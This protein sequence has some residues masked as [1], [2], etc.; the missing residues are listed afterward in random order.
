MCYAAQ[1]WYSV[2]YVWYCF[3]LAR[4]SEVEFSAATAESASVVCRQGR[5]RWRMATTGNGTVAAV[6]QVSVLVRQYVV[7]SG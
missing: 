4:L 3:V 1:Y 5:A 2:A 7:R 6:K